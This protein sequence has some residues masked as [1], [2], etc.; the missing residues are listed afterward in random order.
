MRLSAVLVGNFT[1]RCY[2]SFHVD[3]YLC[4]GQSPGIF[5]QKQWRIK[6]DFFNTKRASQG[7]FCIRKTRKFAMSLSSTHTTTF[8]ELNKYVGI[9]WI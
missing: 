6:V 8:A 7:L 2:L 5:F 3:S 1:N 4:H 9:M